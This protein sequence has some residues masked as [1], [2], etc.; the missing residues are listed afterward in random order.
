MLTRVMV[1]A[2]FAGAGGIYALLPSRA[3]LSVTVVEPAP[4]RGAIHVHSLRSD[5]TGDVESIAVAA[6]QAGLDFV[7]FT[8]HGDAM[9]PPDPPR[10]LH[11]VLCIDAVELSTNEGHVIALG[12]PRAPYPLGGEA[13]DV[14]EDIS[15]LGGFSIAA[16]PE[17][18]KTE[19]RWSD[20]DSEPS[21]L[22][23]LNT[24]SEWRDESIWSLARAL[25]TYPIRGTET[26]VTLLDRPVDTLERWDTLTQSRSVVAVAGADA[27]ARIGFWSIGEPY[28]SGSF[29]HV[30]S[31]ERM[32]Q[33]FSNA[34]PDIILSGDAVGDTE[35]V[36]GAI[37]DGNVYSVVDGLGLAAAM[38][39]TASSGAMTAVAGEA[40]RLD[41]PVTLRVGLQGPDTARIEILKNGRVLETATGRSL[42]VVVDATAAVYR[43][44]VALPAGPGN[45]PVPWI[46][47]NPIY[48]GREVD[49]TVISDSRSEAF[50]FAVQYEDG[51]ASDW[52]V[53]TSEASL[54]AMDAVSTVDNTQLSLRYG[55]GGTATANPFVA[56]AMPAGPVLI[57]YDR[58]IF[59]AWANRPMRFSVQLREPQGEAGER[60]HRSVY[61]DSVPR[62]ISVYFDDFRATGDASRPLPN[63]EN[64]EAILFVVDTVNSPLGASGTLWIDDVQYGR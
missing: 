44:E 53:E 5:G 24:D 20:W 11:G 60:W 28:N 46:V 9:R 2:L 10:Y 36:L 16:H 40:L 41:G 54:G 62:T 48:V 25:L 30:P 43:V 7:I 31:Y 4:V 26:L 13:R 14:L 47:S 8:D 29:F 49:G 50:E 56:L 1:F 52:E 59:T 35:R 22:E 45:P 38:S 18:P 17:S 27:H 3:G 6:A 58:L 57:D 55:L 23:W 12:L 42:E 33:V 61:V 32:F 51:L 64:V 19:L 37:R 21:G 63:L 39:F 34:L 15:R